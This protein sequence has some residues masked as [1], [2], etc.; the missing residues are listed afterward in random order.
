MTKT[1]ATKQDDMPE[2]SR[3]MDLA[4]YADMV[5][6]LAKPGA[7]ILADLD[8]LDAH[9]IHMAMGVAGEAGELLDAV[10]KATIYRRSLDVGNV[11]EEL[12]DL[13]FYL[14]GMRQAIRTS[15][16][17]VLKNNMAKLAVRYGAVYSDQ[18][19]R[20]RADKEEVGGMKGES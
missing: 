16:E 19:A 14:E 3:K 7:D 15:R 6:R 13:E 4:N 5:K 2:V 1:M 10:K 12:G 9:L 18:A 11:I 8:T 20:E 17:L